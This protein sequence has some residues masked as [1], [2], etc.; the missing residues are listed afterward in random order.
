M[1][2]PQSPQPAG[3]ARLAGS[4]LNIV[5]QLQKNRFGGVRTTQG[6]PVGSESQ[7]SSLFNALLNKQPNEQEQNAA[8]A[9]GTL[10]KAGSE[11]AGRQRNVGQRK[12]QGSP[13]QSP[14]VQGAA[15]S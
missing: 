14:Q 15:F 4:M 1:D 13:G 6:A 2:T 11:E 12:A 7:N 9:P 10:Q 8:P 5:Q 3:D